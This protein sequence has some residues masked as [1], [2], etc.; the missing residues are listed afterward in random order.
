[1]SDPDKLD[2]LMRWALTFD[3]AI[4]RAEV[5]ALR[6]RY[7]GMQRDELARKI[8]TREAWKAAAMGFATG[9]PGNLLIA[10]PA[11]AAD[12]VAMLRLEASEAVK[13]ATI[14]DPEY[15]ADHEPQYELLVPIFGA[16]VV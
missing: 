7:A 11:G 9:L 10:L 15:L 4:V 6:A 1:M 12:A 5:E 14:Y 2:K 16:G 13:V 8:Y 3:P